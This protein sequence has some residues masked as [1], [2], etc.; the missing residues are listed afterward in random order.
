MLES[1]VPTR[2]DAFKTHMRCMYAGSFIP[3][4]D[5]NGSSDSHELPG[6]L[7]IYQVLS[8]SAIT[9]YGYLLS[10]VEDKYS[11]CIHRLTV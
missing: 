3:E 6:Q 4:V 9:Q 2:S 11:S 5:L 1:S 8:G 10:L 7:I